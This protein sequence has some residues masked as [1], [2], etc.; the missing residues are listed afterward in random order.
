MN[1]T[2]MRGVESMVRE[3]FP[4]AVFER[5]PTETDDGHFDDSPVADWFGFYGEDC[6]GSPVNEGANQLYAAD[7]RFAFEGMDTVRVGFAVWDAA[8][9]MEHEDGDSD[10][11]LGAAW[12][13]LTEEMGFDGAGASEWLT[14]W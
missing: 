6:G 4:D 8:W 9:W 7:M 13:F 5:V 3:A 12:G 11:W 2:E 10:R 14:Q 1:E